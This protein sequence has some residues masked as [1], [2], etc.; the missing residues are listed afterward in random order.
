MAIEHSNSVELPQEDNLLDEMISNDSPVPGHVMLTVTC[1]IGKKIND[2]P[3][4]MEVIDLASTSCA[5][6]QMKK[7][8]QCSFDLDRKCKTL[9]SR[10]WKQPSNSNEL[11]GVV[12]HESNNTMHSFIQTGSVIKLKA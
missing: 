10:N 8:E 7:R 9:T 4:G 5:M 2:D 6:M 1:L 12:Q 11:P 3:T